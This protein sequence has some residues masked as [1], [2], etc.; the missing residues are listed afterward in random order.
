[1]RADQLGQP[2]R[3]LEL[4]DERDR[5]FGAGA[6]GPEA[7]LLRVRMLRRLSRDADA[8]ELLDGLRQALP[9]SAQLE[10]AELRVQAGR[11]REAL[12]D[13][14]T[15]LKGHDEAAAERAL[16]GRAICEERLGLTEAARGDFKQLMLLYPDGSFSAAARRALAK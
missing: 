5:R 15:I 10:R 1:M 8:L 14:Q 9:A 13:F 7:T 4:L 3:A 16:Y 12:S 2:G 6:L 11:M